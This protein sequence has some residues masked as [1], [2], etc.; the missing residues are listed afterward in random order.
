MSFTVRL[1][2]NRKTV[3]V[4]PHSEGPNIQMDITYQIDNKMLGGTREATMDI[5]YN[6]SPFYYKTI[7]EKNGLRHLHGMKASR[8][9]PIL[10]QAIRI[11]GTTPSYNYW[12][13]DAGN[14]GKALATLLTWAEQHP[15][16]II[17]VY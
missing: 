10:K 13:S 8:A 15:N 3:L 6:Y 17:E 1:T 16:A 9:I 14:A 12:T 5:T 7:N 2:K 4:E 11:L